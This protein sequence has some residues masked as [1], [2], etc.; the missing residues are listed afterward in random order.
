MGYGTDM[1]K[2]YENFIPYAKHYAGKTFT[3][4]IES[5]NC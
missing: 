5:L 3:T 4:Q 1:L 2:V